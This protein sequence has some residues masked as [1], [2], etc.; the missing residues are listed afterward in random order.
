MKILVYEIPVEDEPQ[1][2]LLTAEMESV[3]GMKPTRIEES[4]PEQKPQ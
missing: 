2:Q 1:A 4:S 3:P